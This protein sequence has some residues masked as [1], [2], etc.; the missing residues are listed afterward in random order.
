MQALLNDSE[1]AKHLG[2]GLTLFRSRVA[3]RLEAVRI[4]RRVLYRVEDLDAWARLG[5]DERAGRARLC[6]T[7]A[8]RSNAAPENPIEAQLRQKR[9]RPIG[10]SSA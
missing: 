10:M 9:R 3:P 4:G 1:A 8:K 2:I 5:A 6:G 7:K